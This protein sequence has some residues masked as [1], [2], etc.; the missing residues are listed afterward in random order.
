MLA[1]KDAFLSLSLS[2]SVCLSCLSLKSLSSFLRV[3][4]RARV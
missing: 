1:F 3:R 2:L 4:F